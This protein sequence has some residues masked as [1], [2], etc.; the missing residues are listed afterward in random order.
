MG[1][2]SDDPMDDPMD[3]DEDMFYDAFREEGSSNNLDWQVVLLS[4]IVLLV[5]WS[6]IYFKSTLHLYGYMYVLIICTYNSCN[7]DVLDEYSSFFQSCDHTH[8]F[9]T[10]KGT[11]KPTRKKTIW[12]GDSGA[13]SH[14]SPHK[15]D[16]IEY[17]EFIKKILVATANK[18]M[19]TFIHGIGTVIIKHT[20]S[21]GEVKLSS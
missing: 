7:F 19:L 18:N 6:Q 8:D 9:R 17:R 4:L 10:K 5:L 13:S 16:F 12:I 15:S 3:Y 20:N 11:A 14:F 1:P 21:D 2:L